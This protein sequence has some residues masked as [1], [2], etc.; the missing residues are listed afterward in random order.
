M[1]PT[2]FRRSGT[3]KQLRISFMM[4]TFPSASKIMDVR[5][6]N[7]E[8]DTERYTLKMYTFYPNVLRREIDDNEE[9]RNF[10]RVQH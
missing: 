2:L 10:Y 4:G 9:E 8:F 1:I 6:N 7:L 5:N 3:L